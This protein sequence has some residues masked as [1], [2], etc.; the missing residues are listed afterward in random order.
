[1]RAVSQDAKSQLNA[2]DVIA[3]GDHIPDIKLT[4]IPETHYHFYVN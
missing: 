1:M 3:S 2:R 4:V